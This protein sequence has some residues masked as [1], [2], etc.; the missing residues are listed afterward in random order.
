MSI[1]K[2]LEN[3]KRERERERER[4]HLWRSGRFISLFSQENLQVEFFVVFHASKQS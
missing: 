2:F 1:R 4:E 3:W